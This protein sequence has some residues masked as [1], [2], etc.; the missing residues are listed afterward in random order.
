MAKSKNKVSVAKSTMVSTPVTAVQDTV[1]WVKITPNPKPSTAGGNPPIFVY[2]KTTKS[3][4]YYWFPATFTSPSAAEAALAGASQGWIDMLVNAMFTGDTVTI[5]PYDSS[6][7]TVGTLS[8]PES[9]TF[10]DNFS[11]TV[12]GMAAIVSVVDAGN[13]NAVAGLSSP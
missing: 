8:N 7:T 4:N 12:G 6:V 13:F 11:V 10:M 2:F 1:I 3:P 9:A 5:T